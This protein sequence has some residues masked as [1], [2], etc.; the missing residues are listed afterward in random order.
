MGSPIE[1]LEDRLKSF[2]AQL[3]AEYGILDRIVYK[4]KNQHRRCL[5]FQYLLK[6][7]R[8]LKL[9]QSAH[10]E[11]NLNSC[12]LVIHGKRPKQKVNLLEGLKRRKCEGGKYNFLER[13]LGTAR[14]LS[15]M[16][17]PMLKAAIEISILLARSF[18]MGF[19]I[20]VLALIARIRV[21]VQQMLLDVVSVFNIVSSLSH[22]EQSVK[23]NHDGIEI[24]REFYP[25]KEDV[26]T[27]E[28]IWQTDKFVLHERVDRSKMEN[29]DA[30]LGGG[31]SLGASAIQYQTIQTFLG[32]EEPSKADPS[33]NA[34]EGSVTI[35]DDKTNSQVGQSVESGVRMLAEDCETVGHGSSI[36]AF[37]SISRK[38]P[39]EGG[40]GLSLASSEDP[41]KEKKTGSRNKVA[42]ISIKRPAPPPTTDAAKF[43]GKEINITN[44][45]K[46][47][48]FLDLLCDGNLKDSL[49]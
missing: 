15:Q 32:D 48:P 27:L 39:Q 10:L 2:I 1:I 44:S 9:L 13:L 26:I 30:E 12:F 6:V 5:Y 35:A 38:H 16:I 7:R 29:R 40:S 20:T 45:G 47:D 23:L 19:S 25:K 8:D 42:F 22:K 46:E 31:L 14:L 28:C 11:D 17:E 4:N 24:F 33:N 34:E 3:Q 43:Q 18:F 41:L 37:P 21:L 49:F 36:A